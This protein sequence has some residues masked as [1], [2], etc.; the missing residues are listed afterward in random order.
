MRSLELVAE[1]CCGYF[2]EGSLRFEMWVLGLWVLVW[3]LALT[4]GFY[5]CLELDFRF[6]YNE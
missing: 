4:E 5:L 6:A 1:L 3:I 2:F